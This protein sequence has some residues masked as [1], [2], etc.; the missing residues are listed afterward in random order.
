M[1]F[2]VRP[3][4]EV[5]GR[6][7]RPVA[8]LLV[9]SGERLDGLVARAETR[10]VAVER[11]DR[12]ALSTLCGSDSHQGVAVVVSGGFPYVALEDL[13][14]L[15]QPL[16]L[17]VDGV[18]DP[19][20]LGAMIR[21]ALVFGATGLVLPRDRCCGVTSTVVRVSAGAAE[22]LPCA[23][24]TNLVRALDQLKEANV[25]VAGTV[26]RGGQDPAAAR[27]DGALALVLGNEQRGLRRLVLRA[28]DLQLTIPSAGAIASLNVAAATAALFH[29]V[30]RQRRAW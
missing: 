14:E 28:C 21:S 7:D 20:N 26:E 5:L 10:G 12:D 18:T 27:L 3:V 2:G 23:Q 17:V 1:V 24:V 16:L 30:A 29:E 25:W 6:A 9:T 15:E 4:G 8:R 19:Q 11:V 22:H 13:V